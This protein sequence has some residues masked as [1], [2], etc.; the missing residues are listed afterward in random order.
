MFNNSSFNFNVDDVSHYIENFDCID[1]RHFKEVTN[2]LNL[3]NDFKVLVINARSICQVERFDE[4]KL[5]LSELNL[6]VNIVVVSE[7]WIKKDFIH[8][9]SIDGYTS[10]FS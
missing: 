3:S 9:Y 6:S 2:N 5:L 10:Y 1:V 7:T 4:L 8:L